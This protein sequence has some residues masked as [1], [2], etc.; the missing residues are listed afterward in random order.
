MAI[1][2]HVSRQLELSKIKWMWVH[3]EYRLPILTTGLPPMEDNLYSNSLQAKAETTVELEEGIPQALRVNKPKLS[4]AQLSQWQKPKTPTT[5][6]NK[7]SITMGYSHQAKCLLSV[8]RWCINQVTSN[9]PSTSNNC[10]SSPSRD[11]SSQ[12]STTTLLT[13]PNSRTLTPSMR[14]FPGYM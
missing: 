5:K 12:P 6:I 4:V 13:L 14:L 10:I 2:V 8:V 11:S 1:L 3:Q 9:W 7:C